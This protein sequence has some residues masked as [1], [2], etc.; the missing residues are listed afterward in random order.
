MVPGAGWMRTV[1]FLWFNAASYLGLRLPV[2]EFLLSP[3]IWLAF[4]TLTALEIVLGIDN[5]IFISIVT[6]RLPKERRHYPDHCPAH[7][8]EN[9]FRQ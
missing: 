1:R 7:P 9:H 4:I 3:E 6:S 5:I 2:P 8:R